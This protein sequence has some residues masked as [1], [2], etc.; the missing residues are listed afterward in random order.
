MS[1]QLIYFKLQDANHVINTVKFL[2]CIT[3]ALVRLKV[4]VDLLLWQLQQ[5]KDWFLCPQEARYSPPSG[6]TRT[7]FVCTLFPFLIL[8]RGKELRL[9]LQRQNSIVII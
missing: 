7:E 5:L 1:G 3:A 9:F 4:P 2:K 8:W 6:L